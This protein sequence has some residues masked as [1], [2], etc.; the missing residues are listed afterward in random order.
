MHPW[1]CTIPDCAQAWIMPHA[2]KQAC[3]HAVKQAC[4]LVVYIHMGSIWGVF[5]CEIWAKMEDSKVPPAFCAHIR[6]QAKIMWL[7]T[8][9]T[10]TKRSTLNACRSVLVS[11]TGASPLP[12]V[13]ATATELQSFATAL[14]R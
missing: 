8:P 11:R 1:H 13:T 2:V 7:L 6:H 9:Q 12:H 10:L 5:G 14:L 3:Q 4:Q